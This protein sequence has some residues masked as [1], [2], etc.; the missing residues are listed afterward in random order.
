[1][2]FALFASK[3]V[4]IFPSLHLQLSI[5][6]FLTFLFPFSLWFLFRIIRNFHL[7]SLSFLSNRSACFL[8]IISLSVSLEYSLFFLVSFLLVDLIRPFKYFIF[9]V[10]LDLKFL[11]IS[12]ELFEV[13][14][15]QYYYIFNW[16]NQVFIEMLLSLRKTTLASLIC[17]SM[18]EYED[19]VGVEIQPNPLLL[20]DNYE[21]ASLDFGVF[22][23]IHFPNRYLNFLIRL[24]KMIEIVMGKNLNHY[25]EFY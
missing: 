15:F 5:R 9:S 19:G 11:W 20:P 18:I 22:L 21:L 4:D 2:R 8:C 17:E 23:W 3:D 10:V 24:L 16:Q 13:F 6:L 14:C 1:M 7:L 12:V 25:D